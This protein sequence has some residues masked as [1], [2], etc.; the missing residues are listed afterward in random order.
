MLGA[1]WAGAG[2]SGYSLGGRHESAELLFISFFSFL[3]PHYVTL[4][5][6]EHCLSFPGNFYNW[7]FGTKCAEKN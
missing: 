1:G 6:V 5:N 3:F 7:I 2:F 4:H